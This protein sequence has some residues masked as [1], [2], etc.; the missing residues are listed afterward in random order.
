MLLTQNSALLMQVTRG[1]QTFLYSRAASGENAPR[2]GMAEWSK[3]AVLKT[4]R[5]KALGGSNPSPSV[6]FAVL[7]PFYTI[8]AP[9]R[10]NVSPARQEG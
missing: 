8:L 9:A 10:R 2:G 6:F 5:A 7:A 1:G 4:V 3:A